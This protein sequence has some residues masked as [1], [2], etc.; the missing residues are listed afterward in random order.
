LVLAGALNLS[1]C[2]SRALLLSLAAT[3]LMSCSDYAATDPP[4]LALPEREESVYITDQTSLMGKAL[5]L[6]N[7]EGQCRLKL[8]ASSGKPEQSAGDGYIPALKP[9]APCYF[10]KSP[11]T[12]N[13]QVFRQD[14]TTRIF[15]VLGTP[16]ASDEFPGQ[17][18][19]REV[20]GVIM[21]GR[22][23]VTLSEYIIDNAIYCAGDGLDN[24][25]YA[26]F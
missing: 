2:W 25:Q 1:G 8:S 13:V 23:K 10:I 24:S 9:A 22:G 18:C 6:W 5:S 3:A 20:Q 17:R 26:L 21:D 7:D 12:R 11:G 4:A 15:A 19:G 14:K 16:V